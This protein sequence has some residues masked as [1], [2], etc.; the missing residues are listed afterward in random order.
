MLQPFAAA[1]FQ[2]AVAGGIATA[3]RTGL[4]LDGVSERP[5]DI[6]TGIGRAVIDNDYFK[7]LPALRQGALDGCGDPLLRVEARDQDADEG[8]HDPSAIVS[9]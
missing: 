1:Q 9:S 8:L 2:Q 4:V 5:D 3:V 6:Q 7:V